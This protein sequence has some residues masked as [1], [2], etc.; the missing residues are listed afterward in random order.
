M[1]H[2]RHFHW[3][4]NPEQIGFLLLGHLE[5]I[6]RGY[7]VLHHGIECFAGDAAPFVRRYDIGAGVLA[8]SAGALAQ[9]IDETP[10]VRRR[11]CGI[12]S[13]ARS[14]K[15]MVLDPDANLV[16]AM[17]AGAFG[18]RQGMALVLYPEGERSIDGTP[19]IFKKGAAI[20]S[21]HL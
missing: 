20:L 1:L 18:L 14:I 16:P 11:V 12:G 10:F 19:R 5:L 15:V 21:I 13:V 2:D 6:E 4:Q 17:R 7:Q 9:E 8:W 3:H